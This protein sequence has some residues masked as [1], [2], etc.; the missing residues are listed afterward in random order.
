MK[1]P[2]WNYHGTYFI[3]SIEDD[4]VYGPNVLVGILLLPNDTGTW[5]AFP[6]GNGT[7]AT[8]TFR[9]LIQETGLEK[10]PL[11]CALTLVDTM[12]MNDDLEEISHNINHGTFKMYPTNAA[13]INHDY[14]VDMKD[15]GIAAH[16]FG[17]VPGDPRWNPLADITGPVTWVPDGRVDMRDIGTI[18]RNFGWR[19]L[20]DP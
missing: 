10:L 17:T 4:P 1:D 19:P 3:L 6:Y 7:L 20:N 12:I 11:T 5:E 13:D 2:A 8:I 18:A 9:T 15:V 16:A 14:K